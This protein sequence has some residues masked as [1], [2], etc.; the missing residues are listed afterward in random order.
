[1]AEY[2]PSS[3]Q[4]TVEKRSGGLVIHLI[5]ELGLPPHTDR[6]QAELNRVYADCPKI[7]VFDMLKLSFVSSLGIG[8]FAE[9]NRTLRRKSGQLKLCCVQ[10]KVMEV[11]E[12]T[13]MTAI[14]EFINKIEDGFPAQ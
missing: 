2:T 1:M 11:F 12:R 5:G 6:L 9:A 7:L 3:L 13:R 8:I 14:F 10:P 4:F